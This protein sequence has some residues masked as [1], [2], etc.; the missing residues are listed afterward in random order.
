MMTDVFW[1]YLLMSSGYERVS[2]LV[3]VVCWV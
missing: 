2:L 1:V 3:V